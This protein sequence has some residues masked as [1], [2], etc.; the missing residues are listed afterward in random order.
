MGLFFNPPCPF[1]SL[2]PRYSPQ[3]LPLQ[4]PQ[5][6][7]LMTQTKFDRCHH[8]HHH[9]RRRPLLFKTYAFDPFQ[10]RNAHLFL[11]RP[12]SFPLPCCA[13]GFPSE[14]RPD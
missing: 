8:H 13:S 4:Q 12:T 5:P 6:L 2:Q 11:V 14:I 10:L 1:L 9:R 3:L 7:P